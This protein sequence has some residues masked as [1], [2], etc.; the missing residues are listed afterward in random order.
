MNASG[1][2]GEIHDSLGVRPRDEHQILLIAGAIPADPFD[3][4]SRM[5]Q[6]SPP[7]SGETIGSEISAHLG[8]IKSTPHDDAER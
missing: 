1:G 6:Q 8:P 5:P 7:K 4:K 2:S 3:D